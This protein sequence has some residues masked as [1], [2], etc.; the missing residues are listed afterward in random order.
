MTKNSNQGGGSCLKGKLHSKIIIS[1]LIDFFFPVESNGEGP[2]S[3][4]EQEDGQ[5]DSG[6][7]WHVRAFVMSVVPPCNHAWS[8]ERF[9]MLMI[10]WNQ[11]VR[12][13]P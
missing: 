5:T 2:R 13:V 7:E 9:K 4:F 10:S 3:K 12:D 8:S 1:D 11:F 6:K